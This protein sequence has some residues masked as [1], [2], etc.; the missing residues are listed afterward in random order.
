MLHSTRNYMCFLV[1]AAMLRDKL[2]QE[3]QRQYR[4]KKLASL[5][6]AGTEL[7]NLLQ[8]P[9]YMAFTASHCCL[10]YS[11]LISHVVCVTAEREQL[12]RKRAEYHQKYL[13]AITPAG[14]ELS[15]LLQQP[16]Y[17]FHSFPLLSVVQHI[18]ISCRLCDCR[19]GAAQKEA[20]RVS[21]EVLGC[22]NSSRY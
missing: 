4:L 6:P 17:D 13:A 1:N 21:S 5:T 11:T 16:G 9:G 14:T 12:K 18:D 10:L 19:K 2:R 20:S 7:S 3:R 8:Q 15:N 22:F